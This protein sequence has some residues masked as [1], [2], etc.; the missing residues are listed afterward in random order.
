[1]M[2]RRILRWLLVAL[3]LSGMTWLCLEYPSEVWQAF[4]TGSMILSVV[5]VVVASV[6]LVMGCYC[7]VDDAFG[8]NVLWGLGVLMPPVV[9]AGLWFGGAWLA[10]SQ[11]SPVLAQVGSAAGVA[12]ASACPVVC[13]V[14]L[15]MRWRQFRNSAG[16]AVGSAGYLVAWVLLMMYVV[17]TASIASA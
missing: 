9:G 11:G 4:K 13:V 14:L 12:I 6:V 2:V 7:F 8:V 1:M 15:V 16:A 3:A 10:A 5:L 17:A